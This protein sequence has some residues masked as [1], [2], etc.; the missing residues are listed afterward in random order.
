MAKERDTG[1]FWLIIAIVVY[2]L[3]QIF[4]LPHFGITT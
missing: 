3:L 2:L 4:I 1:M